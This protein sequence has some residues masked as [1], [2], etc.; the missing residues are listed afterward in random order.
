VFQRRVQSALYVDWANMSAKFPSRTLLEG[1]PAWL[2]WLEDGKF[3]GDRKR[4]TFLEKRA[5]INN[6]FL[7]QIPA[8]E[9]AGFEVIP[10]SDDML[11]ALDMADSSLKKRHIDEYIL[12]SV[13]ED[14]VHLLERLGERGRRKQRVVTVGPEGDARF[15]CS[16]TFPPRCEITIPLDHMQKAFQYERAQ[17][18]RRFIRSV[19]AQLARWR[20]TSKKEVE[21]PVT[22]SQDPMLLRIAEH[23]ATLAESKRG[24]PVGKGSVVRYLQKNV[25]NFPYA[26]SYR[27]RFD[28]LLRQVV[29]IRKDLQLFRNANGNLAIMAPRPDE[30]EA[31]LA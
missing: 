19:R 26:Y 21:P 5:Y 31:P 8:L 28:R 14:F 9:A 1:L 6:T 10:S 18:F 24:V 27:R 29:A 15:P 11:I 16:K 2:A 30:S 23:V 4:R 13:D 12:L 17:F 22:I 25:P 3:D 7:K 20:I